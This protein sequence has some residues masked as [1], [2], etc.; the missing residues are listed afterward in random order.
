VASCP[1]RYVREDRPGLD[2]ARNRGVAAA[3]HGLVAF[4]DDDVRVDR[5]WLSALARAF[6]DP[7]TMLVT[8]RV[9]PAELDTEAQVLFEF[10]YGGMEKGERPMRWHRDEVGAGVLAAHHLGV[11]ASM[12]FRRRVFDTVGL[13][14][15]ALD[16]GTPARGAGDLDMFHRVLASGAVARYA[17]DALAW[18]V[19]RRTLEGLRAQ[20]RD[21]GCAFGVYL[22][23]RW[24]E[25]GRRGSP[26]SRLDVAAHALGAWL[27]WLALPF[28]RREPLPIAVRAQELLGALEAPRAARA[29][30]RND[31]A[32][33]RLA[34][35]AA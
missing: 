27:P 29:A 17:P 3:R 25:A 10:G 33:R 15:T 18:H 8:G 21:N 26:I 28:V 32:L 4:T 23:K 19:H 34:R 30:R 7:E 20:I 16:V 12:A 2:W 11:G 1:A 9:A 31:C 13:F 24:A 5:H 22:L 6:A 14:D 35:P